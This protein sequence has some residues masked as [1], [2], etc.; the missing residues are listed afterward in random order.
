MR[1]CKVSQSSHFARPGRGESSSRDGALSPA[2][3][4]SG[5]AWS[6]GLFSDVLCHHVNLQITNCNAL[7]LA[8]CASVW[9][10]FRVRPLVS[11]QRAWFGCFV[12]ALISMVKFFPGVRLLVPHQV[13]WPWRF[14]FTLIAL[15]QFS[16]SVLL[17]MSFEGEG[18]VAW[19]VAPYALVR[20]LPTVNE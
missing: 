10:F 13:A 16:P 5:P 4:R 6:T 15:V 11:L 3:V 8:R 12:I 19:I 1:S 17:D 9:L 2:S 20:F 18:C 7:I 14:I